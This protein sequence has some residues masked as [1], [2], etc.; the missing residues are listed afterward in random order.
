MA[1]FSDFEKI[2][3]RVGK[4]V[5]VEDFPEARKPMYKITVD[6]GPE[7]GMK[8]SAVGATENYTKEQLQGKL[9]LGLVNLPPKQI[10]PF[11]SESLTLG[12]SD[13]NG[14]CVL[15]SPDKDVPLGGRLF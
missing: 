8:R 7:I 3:I 1:N 14:H 5:S 12:V 4:V 10:G 15:I 9:V 6:F 11:T 2:D 13:E